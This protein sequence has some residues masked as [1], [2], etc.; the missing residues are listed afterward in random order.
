MSERY[1]DYERHSKREFE[2][3]AEWENAMHLTGIPS[4]YEARLAFA[5]IKTSIPCDMNEIR[6]EERF[7]YNK[8]ARFDYTMCCYFLFRIKMC[9]TFEKVIVDLYDTYVHKLMCAYYE[10]FFNLT[11]EKMILLIDSRVAKYEHALELS[12]KEFMNEIMESLCQFVERD[13]VGEPESEV[14][15]IGDFVQHFMLYSNLSSNVAKTL[16]ILNQELQSVKYALNSQKRQEEKTKANRKEEKRSKQSDK[17]FN[18][19]DNFFSALGTFGAILYFI[20]SLVISAL[21]FMMIGGNFF[22]RLLLITIETFFPPISI[23]FWIWGLIC[24]IQGVQDIWAI[25]YYIA[26]AVLWLPFY[27]S[28]IASFFKR[29]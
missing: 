15:V 10:H 24:A 27:I 3:F 26:F 29:K 5:T 1:Y 9:A 4:N 18:L 17:K 6:V 8:Y 21:P 2:D 14:V 11:E 23:V 16:N 7:F 12:E 13:L 22:V 28:I 19:K 25:I 20:L